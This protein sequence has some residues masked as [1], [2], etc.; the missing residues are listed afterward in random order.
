MAISFERALGL[1]EQALN[2]RTQR[3]EVL[4]NNMANADTP[5]Y[6]ARD[7]DFGLV[8]AQAN[9]S[10]SVRVNTTSNKH[11]S[12]FINS[13]DDSQLLY[14][15]PSQPS[16]DGNTVDDEA[17]TAKY[18]EN[19]MDFQASFRFLDGRFKGLISAIRGE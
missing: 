17:E 1:H 18:M 19:S 13:G 16:I 11:L 8:L 12:G 10:Q 2:F 6:K 9:E 14:S 15:N 7:L 3:A 4:A 5:G